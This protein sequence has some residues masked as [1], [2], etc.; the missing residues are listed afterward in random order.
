MVGQTE[1]S[2]FLRGYKRKKI[3]AKFIKEINEVYKK[4]TNTKLDLIEEVKDPNDKRYKIYKITQQLS[5]KKSF[6]SFFFK[7]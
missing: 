7:I 4:V 6:I 1:I 2:E 5:Q 3:W